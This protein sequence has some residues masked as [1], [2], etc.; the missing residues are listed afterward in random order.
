MT[1]KTFAT[2]G[3]SVSALIVLLGILVIA[4][5]MG[6]DTSYPGMAPYSYD[7]GYASFGGDFYTYV[8][9]NAAEAASGART[10]AANLEDIAELLKNVCGVFL[11]GFGL[12]GVCF[13][14]MARC[15]CQDKKNEEVPAELPAAE[16]PAEAAAE[17]ES[18]SEQ[19]T[20]SE[21]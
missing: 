8:N 15:G 21:E 4:G 20:V 11:M 7:S 19:E 2:A 17:Q 3:M 14:G 13:F 1:K 12:M 9:N 16:M 18:V 6:G 10:A 5:A